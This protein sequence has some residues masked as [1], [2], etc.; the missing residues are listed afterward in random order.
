MERGGPIN[1]RP[2]HGGATAGRG[3]CSGAGASV[4]RGNWAGASTSAAICMGACVYLL[5]PVVRVVRRT[6][7]T[8]EPTLSVMGPDDDRL[9]GGSWSSKQ[10]PVW[11]GE[12]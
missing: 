6:C 5:V 8:S 1:A 12:I 11:C 2:R 7:S 9:W 3:G 10:T 4:A